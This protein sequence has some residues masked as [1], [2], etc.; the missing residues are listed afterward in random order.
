MSGSD[1]DDEALDRVAA[2]AEQA[3]SPEASL[4]AALL[5]ADAPTLAA[6]QAAAEA[7]AARERNVL[8][9]DHNL[10]REKGMEIA[11]LGAL[12]EADTQAANPARPRHVISTHPRLRFL[13]AF[14]S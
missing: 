1:G 6:V 12:Q 10:P 11:I 14:H 4:E 9:G 8:G 5:A 7:I 13:R 2:P 3:A